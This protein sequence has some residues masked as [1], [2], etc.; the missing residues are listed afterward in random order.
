[1]AEVMWFKDGTPSDHHMSR[2]H[3]V[4]MDRVLA[5]LSPFATQYYDAPPTFNTQHGPA[6]KSDPY[7]YV[8]VKVP[9]EAV[10]GTFPDDGY[11]HDIQLEPQEMR[12]LLR[13]PDESLPEEP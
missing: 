6:S 9:D 3:H 10:N 1:M 4:P 5:A 2:A 11:Y 8:L 7:R 13:F 12:R